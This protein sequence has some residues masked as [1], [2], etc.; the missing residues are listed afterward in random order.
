MQLQVVLLAELALLV[1]VTPAAV[2]QVEPQVMQE[3][4]V[5]VL[6]L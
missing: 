6:E 3:V 2:L 1:K 4:V 5:V